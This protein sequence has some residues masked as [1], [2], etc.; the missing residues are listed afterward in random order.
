MTVKTWVVAIIAFALLFGGARYLDHR[1]DAP[2]VVVAVPEPQAE[3]EPMAPVAP[4]VPATKPA[5]R[6]GNVPPPPPHKRPAAHVAAPQALPQPRPFRCYV[7][8]ECV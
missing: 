3:P 1:H 4:V 6:S 8:F 2:A 5:K 7:I